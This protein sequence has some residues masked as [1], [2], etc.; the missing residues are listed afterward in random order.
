MASKADVEGE[1]GELDRFFLSH[2]QYLKRLHEIKETVT[3]EY[4]GSLVQRFNKKIKTKRPH[5]KTIVIHRAE[6]CLHMS[7]ILI[8]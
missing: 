5:L 7:T 1:I 4:Y 8:C 3:A 6:T 2:R